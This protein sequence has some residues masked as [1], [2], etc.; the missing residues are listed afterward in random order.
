MLQ[1]R[2]AGCATLP[3]VLRRLKLPVEGEPRPT[4]EQFLR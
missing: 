3:E 4:P 2:L 1:A